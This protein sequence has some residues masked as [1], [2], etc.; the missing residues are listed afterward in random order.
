MFFPQI[1]PLPICLSP[2][3]SVR[4]TLIMLVNSTA[5]TTHY[6]PIHTHTYSIYIW[7]VCIYI[8]EMCVCVCEFHSMYCAARYNY[9]I[10]N[11]S[12]FIAN[13]AWKS[14]SSKYSRHYKY[15][16]HSSKASENVAYLCPITSLIFPILMYN[17]QKFKSEKHLSFFWYT[18]S[19]VG[20]SV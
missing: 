5:Y 6:T 2:I 17:R 12:N 9:W 16:Y 19:G 8:Y 7:N 3:F 14:S 11:I 15:K 4:L 10:Y 20:N 1:S 18:H 13:Y